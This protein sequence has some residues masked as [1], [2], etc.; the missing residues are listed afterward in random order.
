MNRRSREKASERERESEI[1]S[2]ELEPQLPPGWSQP[3]IDKV[4]HF[5]LRKGEG[6]VFFISCLKKVSK[7]IYHLFPPQP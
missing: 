4:Q 7:D 1:Q 6:N 5:K 2:E 3:D